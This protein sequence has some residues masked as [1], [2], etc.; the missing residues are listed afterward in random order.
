MIVRCPP[1]CVALYLRLDDILVAGELPRDGLGLISGGGDAETLNEDLEIR[2]QMMN[3]N[4]NFSGK[5]V[6]SRRAPAAAPWTGTRAG[7]GA[8]GGS[9][10]GP[11][12]K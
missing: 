8:G 1:A 6:A 7:P 2:M 4:I 5:C 9:W 11:W 3:K 12:W 10:K